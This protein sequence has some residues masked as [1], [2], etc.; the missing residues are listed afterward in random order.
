MTAA[1]ADRT[2]VLI[3]TYNERD[4]IGRLLTEIHQAAD[5][6]VFIVDD[7]SPDGTG[8]F[9]DELAT[10]DPRISVLHRPRKMGVASAHVT[11]FRRCLDQGYASIIEMD[12]DFSHPPADIPRLIEAAGKDGVGLGSRSVKGAAIVGR[13]AFRNLLTRFGA[14]YARVILLLPVRDCT[15]GYR[16]ST[17]AALE[18]I[19][20]DRIRSAGYGMQI[21]LNLAW[22]R[23]DVPVREVPITFVDRVVGTSKMSTRILIE[24]FVV[25]LKLRFGLI[26][27]SVKAPGAAAGAGGSGGT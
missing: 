19:D 3:A 16:C 14:A 12:G 2:M 15:G 17:R 9:V 23:A 24:A 11:A 21:E 4:N 8:E 26:R 25:V 27:V 10:A 6:D 22:K 18:R 5:V 20:L 13:S 7:N 1:H